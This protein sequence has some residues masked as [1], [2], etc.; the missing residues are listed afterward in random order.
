MFIIFIILITHIEKLY[1]NLYNVI[2]TECG[3]VNKTLKIVFISTVFL[4]AIVVGIVAFTKKDA[5]VYHP[6]VS[7]TEAT[8]PSTTE[9]TT[10]TTTEKPTKAST[11]S[12]YQYAKYRAPNAKSADESKHGRILILVNNY[13]ELP[14]DFQW[15]LVYWSNGQAV[16][17]SILNKSDFDIQAID[18][19]A[20]EPLKAM[21]NAA[22]EAGVPLEFYSGYRSIVRQNR[23]F[24]RSVENNMKSGLSLEDAKLKTNKSRAYPGTSEHNV[25]LA[26]DLLAKGSSDLSNNFEKTPQFKWLMENAEN[27]GFVLRYPKD[28]TDITEIIYEPWHYRYVGVEHAKKMNQ[29]NMCLE[30]YI[31][32]LES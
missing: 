24:V 30:E 20:Y 19:M 11:N 29:L 1:K 2:Y 25:G 8:T 5:E 31:E 14:E 32:Y 22:E 23:N 16:D 13:N 21:F 26:I 15:N 4:V 17:K 6:S 27:Y 3:N 18:E 9:T 28:K 7:T 10:E 12:F